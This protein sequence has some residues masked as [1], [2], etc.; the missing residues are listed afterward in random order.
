MKHFLIAIATA[1]IAMTASVTT[2]AADL[3]KGQELLVKGNCAACHGEGMNKPVVAEY[4]KLAGQHADYLYFALRA[5]KVTNNPTVGRSNAI[6]AGQVA[7]FSD[8]DLKDM[9]AYIASLPGNL[10]VKK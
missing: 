5:Y 4:P 8:R 2:Q 9:A 6:M 7:Q 3:K 1:S 10:V